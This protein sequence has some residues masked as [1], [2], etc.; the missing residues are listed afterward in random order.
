[1]VPAVDSDVGGA[2]LKTTWVAAPAVNVTTVLVAVARV[3]VVSVAT[4][5]QLV[6]LLIVTAVNVATPPMAWTLVVPVSVHAETS[7]ITSVEYGVVTSTAPL[8]SSTDTVK[9]GRTV[10]ALAVAGGSLVKPT[11]VGTVDAKVTTV[12]LDVEDK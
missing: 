11:W 3:L 10:P 1:V 9:V 6:P 8:L 2:V 7:E 5:W 4:N 12:G